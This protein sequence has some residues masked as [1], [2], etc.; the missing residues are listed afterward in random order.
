MA[1][2][3]A[4]RERPA[5]AERPPLRDRDLD[6]LSDREL[7]AL[8]FDGEPPEQEEKEGS[9]LSSGKAWKIAAFAAVM[10][11]AVSKGKLIGQVA[12]FLAFFYFVQK[13][14]LCKNVSLPSFSTPSSHA[15]PGSDATLTRS[16]TDRKLLGVCGGVADYFEV[17]ATLVR[18]GFILGLLVSGGAPVGLVYLVL[19]YLMPDAP[20]A[21]RPSTREERLRIIR[22]S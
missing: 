3:S 8:L 18:F 20:V 6:A 15:P 12:L 11:L 13:G 5:A 22:E 1:F 4:R 7:E 16:A 2:F 17:D 9:W 14:S 19:A 10:I 21:A